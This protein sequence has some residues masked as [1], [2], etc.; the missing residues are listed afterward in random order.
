M[1]IKTIALLN[2]VSSVGL[3][4]FDRSLYRVSDGEDALAAADGIL[5]RSAGMQ[6]MTFPRSLLCIARAGAGVNNIPIERCAEAGI[7]VFNTPGANANGVAELTVCALYL[8]ARRVADGIE[9]AKGLREEVARTVEKGKGQFSGVEAAGKT[10]GVIGL[11]AIGGIVANRAVHLQMQVI[12]CDP[13]LSV[14]A[15]WNLDHRIRRVATFDR[16]YEEADY[17]T[18]HVPATKE[19][20]HM[21][22]AEALAKMKDGVRLLN[23]SRADLVD[24]SALR[25]ALASGK[26]A[27]YVTDFPTEELQGVAGVTAIPHLGASTAESED[28][29]AVMAAQEMIDYLENGNITNSVNYPSVSMPRDGN[30]RICILHRNVPNMLSGI[31]ALISAGGANIE[32]MTNKSRGEYAYT[33]LDIS[34]ALP[35]CTLSAIRAQAGVIRVRMI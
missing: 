16:V 13:F 22:N 29:C 28:R 33:L 2:P 12:G 3:A 4:R 31:T 24:A 5:V 20:K 30:P 32:N 1:S 14:D 27:A 10:L 26:V 6:E 23:F 8:A 21:I 18:L 15:A 11:G 35:A 34:E 9:W 17:I 7:V 25:A 19:T